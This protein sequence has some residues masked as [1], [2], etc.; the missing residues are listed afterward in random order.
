M[1]PRQPEGIPAGGQFAFALHPE[2]PISLAEPRRPELEG[3]PT[4]LP[5]PKL[6]IE[7]GDEME[8]STKL[9]VEGHGSITVFTDNPSTGRCDYEQF[10]GEFEDVDEDTMEKV[11]AWTSERHLEM[12]TELRRHMK[13]AADFISARTAAKATGKPVRASDEDLN[14]LIA[15]AGSVA[16]EARNAGE[17][18][19]MAMFSREILKRHPEAVSAELET[20]GY[21]DGEFLGEATIKDAEG[22]VITTYGEDLTEDE[23]AVTDLLR[24]MSPDADN[25]AWSEYTLRAEEFNVTSFESDSR[26][27]NLAKA[28][29]WAPGA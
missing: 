5:D 29:D 22:N 15:N 28:A 11:V 20:V 7:V 10:V 1:K 16:S 19:T 24:S 9:T 27:L 4:S 17:L 13:M 21:D 14:S 2:A 25:A 18:A 6:S 8:V 3:W 12:E 23:A 26:T